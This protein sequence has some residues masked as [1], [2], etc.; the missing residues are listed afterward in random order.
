MN[1]CEAYRIGIWEALVDCSQF[2]SLDQLQPGDLWMCPIV[3]V[4]DWRITS[5]S[6]DSLSLE[7]YIGLW[8][9]HYVDMD[10]SHPCEWDEGAA[11]WLK[12]A[13]LAAQLT[14]FS[15]LW[16]SRDFIIQHTI[17]WTEIILFFILCYFWKFDVFLHGST[18]LE[19]VFL[20]SGRRKP[21]PPVAEKWM[22]AFRSAITMTSISNCHFPSSKPSFP[23]DIVNLW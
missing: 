16:I 23:S 3:K 20:K 7:Y 19:D 17:I 18:C 4:S 11:S 21:T 10:W 8:R 2:T 6:L 12:A 1:C 9:E 5:R 14:P 22:P 15:A 13:S